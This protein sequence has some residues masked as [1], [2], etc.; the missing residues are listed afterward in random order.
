MR[1]KDRDRDTE[2]EG[3]RELTLVLWCT[4]EGTV[5]SRKYHRQS[6]IGRALAAGSWGYIFS[7]IS[8]DN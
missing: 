5:S 3:K 7:C 6:E 2:T 1:V 4:L 8:I